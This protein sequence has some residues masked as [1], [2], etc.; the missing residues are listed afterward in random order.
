MKPSE[1]LRPFKK[2]SSRK[3]KKRSQRKRRTVILTDT[4][5]K[6]KLQK[7]VEES[8]GKRLK[9]KTGKRNLDTKQFIRSAGNKKKNRKGIEDYWCL[10]CGGNW[11]KSAPGE[12]RVQCIE[13]RDCAKKLHGWEYF[14]CM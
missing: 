9:H 14:L 12:Q 13:C 11:S 5:E 1:A 10:A 3:T 7:Q 6:V 8:Q 2:A 4:P